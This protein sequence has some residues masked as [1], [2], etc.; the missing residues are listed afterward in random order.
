MYT[1]SFKPT[2]I[3]FLGLFF[4]PVLS[5]A[6]RHINGKVFSS[7]QAEPL[8]YASVGIKGTG[9]G[10][11]SNNL[12]EFSL[13]IQQFGVEDTL[14]VNYLGYQSFQIAIRDISLNQQLLIKL[15]QESQAL[16]EILIETEKLPTA[17]EI[18]AK[19]IKNSKKNYPAKPYQLQAFF[20]QSRQV[21]GEYVSLYEAAV[22]IYAK[23][24]QM[25]NKQF[26]NELFV[27]REFRKSYDFYDKELGRLLSPPVNINPIKGVLLQNSM[28]YVKHNNI[29]KLENADFQ[30]DSVISSQGK[31]FYV[32]SLQNPKKACLYVDASNFALVKLEIFQDLHNYKTII[33]QTFG[34]TLSAKLQSQTFKIDFKEIEGRYYPFFL[35][36]T[37]RST[38]TDLRNKQII[39]DQNTVKQLLVNDIFYTDVRLPT[40]KEQTENV[41]FDQ[42]KLDYN[43]DFWANYT[44]VKQ[45]PAESKVLEDLSKNISLE[46]QFDQK[47]QKTYEQNTPKLIR[48]HQLREDFL[49]LRSLIEKAH[50]GLYQYISRKQWEHLMDSTYQALNQSMSWKEFYK[51]ISATLAA[52]RNGHTIAQEPSWWF[53]Q[54][55]AFFPF[56]VKYLHQK[57]Y[58]DQSLDEQVK[59][60]KGTEILS[61]NGQSVE[62]IRKKA[63]DLIPTDGYIETYK[64]E[65]LALFYA[66]Y[67]HLVLNSVDE[68]VIQYKKSNQQI[69]TVKHPGINISYQQWLENM[70]QNDMDAH[71]PT[72]LEIASETKTAWLTIHQSYNFE[73]DLEKY[74]ASIQS[75]KIENLVIDL[76]GYLGLMED[77]HSSALYAYLVDHPFIFLEELKVQSN[78]YSLFDEDFTYKPYTNTLQEIKEGYFDKLKPKDDYFVW[79][80]EPCH[81]IQQ[82]ARHAFRGQVY[83]LVDGLN[84]SASTDFTTKASLLENVTVI[85]EE[86]GGAFQTFVSGFMPRLT[87]PNSKIIVFIPVW[88][89]FIKINEPIQH[90]KGRGVLPDYQIG[91]T[92]EDFIKGQD[93]VK[94]FVWNLVKAK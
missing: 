22:D 80:G 52:I 12:G 20:R 77:C 41:S 11:V 7:H 88:Q 61:I 43:K 74:F 33:D 42:L 89:S 32:L 48:E 27:I 91:L 63:W 1:L 86:T 21:G 79:E 84:F 10:T 82:P 5:I 8:R 94:E 66:K 9:I 55:N 56:R 4:L 49:K 31:E 25:T 3:I 46:K 76:R 38:L 72:S 34:D 53:A 85:G 73:E 81:G 71:E 92:V 65:M 90:P 64:Y 16:N 60:P 87:L 28:K 58:V 83:L 35:E 14:I 19:I 18:I 40:I 57:L 50:T 93:T 51:V 37:I 75:Q 44:I 62:E 68:F 47:Q 6:Q 15:Q 30:L 54:K 67:I 24:H 29:L 17:A 36:F 26:T 13:S 45:T 70:M 23:N 39:Y 59:L 78:D 69:G 2:I